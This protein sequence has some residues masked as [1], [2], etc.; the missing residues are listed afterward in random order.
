MA[1]YK[2]VKLYVNDV[3]ICTLPM[4]RLEGTLTALRSKGIRN[5]RVEE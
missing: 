1:I 3:L 4:A 2:S 5:I